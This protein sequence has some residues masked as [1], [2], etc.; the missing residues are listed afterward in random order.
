MARRN[1]GMAA[2]AAAVITLG[3]CYG[4]ADTA[5][6]STGDTPP[7]PAASATP[8]TP[9]QIQA[10][11]FG[12]GSAVEAERL[13]GRECA[14]CHVGRNTG[15]IMLQRR[16]PQ[17]TPAQLHLR[18]N[19][20]AAYVRLVVRNGLLNMPPLSRA[21]LSDAELD[22]IAQWLADGASRAGTAR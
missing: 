14:Y 7:P 2:I 12:L 11:T 6:A 4:A 15:T 9:T 20:P 3:A 16:L 22:L 13:Y 5:V 18:A 1:L 19:L 10:V 8:A 21:E 17:G